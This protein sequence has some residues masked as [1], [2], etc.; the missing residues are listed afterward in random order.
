MP[1]PPA[2]WETRGIPD[3]PFHNALM[4]GEDVL[5]P[6]RNS[7]YLRRRAHGWEQ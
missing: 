3:I 7:Q 4:T 1:H 5:G 6:E 2:F